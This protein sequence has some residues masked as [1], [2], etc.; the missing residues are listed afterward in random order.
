MTSSADA[1]K[2]VGDKIDRV[3]EIFGE[4]DAIGL[5]ATICSYG[6][7]SVVKRDGD[8]P[9]GLLDGIEQHHLELLMALYGSFGIAGTPKKPSPPQIVQEVI[10]LTKD[11]DSAFL[12][13]RLQRSN[14]DDEKGAKVEM[15]TERIRFHTQAVR[16]W[17]YFEHV[18]RITKEIFSTD[19]PSFLRVHGFKCSDVLT[20]AHF[21]L[22]HAESVIANRYDV[23]AAVRKGRRSKDIISRYFKFVE[24]LT[25]TPEEVLAALGK[26][27]PRDHAFSFVMSHYELRIPSDLSLTP[28]EISE[29]TGIESSRVERV[30]ERFLLERATPE[31]FDLE[32]T[33]LDNP[34]WT[35]P[36]LKNG[37]SFICP[38]PMLF[39]SHSHRIFTELFKHAGLGA[40]L[41][42]RR[43]KYLEDAVEKIFR[44]CFSEAK[45]ESGVTWSLG[46]DKFETDLIVSIDNLIFLIEAKSHH[47]TDSALRGAPDR[48]K[49]HVRDIIGSSSR[50]SQRLKEVILAAQAGDQESQVICDDID[51]PISRA[52]RVIRL[53]ISLDDLAV[54]SGMEEDLKSLDWIDESVDIAPYFSLADLRCIFEVLDSEIYISH[55]LLERQYFDRFAGMLGDE[56]D[57]LGLY[58]E[59]LFNMEPEEGAMTILSGMSGSVDRY[60]ADRQAGSAKPPRPK[61]HPM[62]MRFL[63]LLDK[64]RKKGWLTFATT[65]LSAG[66]FREM[67]EVRK[68]L[69]ILRKS[70]KKS[71]GDLKKPFCL[72]VKPPQVHRPIVIF[73]LYRAKRRDKVRG[74]IDELVSRAFDEHPHE[75]CMVVF[76]D[77]DNNRIA[78][79]FFFAIREDC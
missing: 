59:T 18:D 11:L 52:T 9:S 17:G 21:L 5:I 76:I 46:S 39:F 68:Q 24:D 75:S 70:V 38:M 53:S 55:Y 57:I 14:F 64:R 26:D 56:I 61:V 35:H 72:Q 15:V 63:G 34:V 36:I 42:D 16:N 13:F 2:Q 37:E 47:L 40:Y 10:D 28:S 58:L 73:A 43:A 33:F 79:G 27:V 3:K 62:L 31:V 30:L 1:L 8:A 12:A 74:S 22:E 19:D 41:S 23:L 50:Q 66:D 54:L 25:G 65:L 29:G 67:G 48:L 78:E 77:I 7:T 49:R 6:V 20:V 44:T 60:F 51:L 69:N 32:R 71:G 4:F 45:I